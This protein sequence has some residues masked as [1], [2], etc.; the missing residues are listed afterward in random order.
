MCTAISGGD[1]LHTGV[2]PIS[3]TGHAYCCQWMKQWRVSTSWCLPC[4][5]CL[6]PVSS[7]AGH[8]Y[9]CQ[10][11][12][13]WRLETVC[14]PMS[15]VRCLCP[16]SLTGGT[17]LFHWMDVAESLCMLMSVLCMSSVT[18]LTS[19]LCIL[20]SVND[21][22]PQWAVYGDHGAYPDLLCCLCG[23][24]PPDDTLSMG[25]I[26]RYGDYSA[27]P[28]LLC[29]LCDV[30]PPDGILCQ[31]AVYR[32]Y[33]AHPDLLFCLCDVFPLAGIFCCWWDGHQ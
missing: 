1:C 4:A 5:W 31:W 10:R 6:C 22:V 3:S 27:H 7:T 28:D 26:W 16:A 21:M 32:D 19:V 11:M 12:K 9:F 24:F 25:S 33:S 30:F 13:W 17:C 8:A 2:C 18:Y 23:V 29:C 15:C 20:L 14:L